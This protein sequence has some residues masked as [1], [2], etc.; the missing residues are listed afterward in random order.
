MYPWDIETLAAGGVVT[1]VD[2]EGGFLFDCPPGCW[3]TCCRTTAVKVDP[4]DVVRLARGLG[5]TTGEILRKCAVLQLNPNT[6]LPVAFLSIVA[7]CPF[8]RGDG[9]CQVYPH[10]PKV[11]RAYPIG[12]ITTFPDRL[13]AHLHKRYFIVPGSCGGKGKT[14]HSLQGWLSQ[15]GLP[16]AY[17]KWDRL[18]RLAREAEI[19]LSYS[20]WISESL[21]WRL[22]TYLY[23]HDA[24]RRG[25]G[26]PE[27]VSDAEFY[28][29]CL[30]AVFLILEA[31]APPRSSLPLGGRLTAPPG[32]RS[33]IRKILL[34]PVE[35]ATPG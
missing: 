5:I 17:A 33:R 7:P 2:P 11:C 29:R 34:E 8:L 19:E 13:P 26:V 23:D 12:H 31:H 1:F 9:R 30:R 32:T 22:F 6:K 16:E 27:G 3:G 20:R 14:W 10:R 18:L 21:S 4:W 25:Y 24:L 35:I 15:E 28:E